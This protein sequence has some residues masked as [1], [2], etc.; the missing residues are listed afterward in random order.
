M[1]LV[2]LA[3]SVTAAPGAARAQILFS[4]YDTTAD[5]SSY[6]YMDECIAAVDRLIADERRVD[7][8]WRDTAL[9]ADE[10][11]REGYSDH[12]V[13]VAKRCM[14]KVKSDTLPLQFTFYWASALLKANRDLEVKDMYNRYVDSLPEEK[15]LSAFI[16]MLHL[17]KNARPIRMESIDETYEKAVEVLVPDSVERLLDL[18]LF[19]ADVK[20]SV[21]D[22]AGGHQYLLEAIA[23]TDTL[24]S[25]VKKRPRYLDVAMSLFLA[26]MRNL[27]EKETVDSISV[28]TQAFNSHVGSLFTRIIGGTWENRSVVNMEAPW[29]NGDFWFTNRSN[30]GLPLGRVSKRGRNEV[31]AFDVPVWGKVNLIAFLR[32]GCHSSAPPP[33]Q[34]RW[35]RLNGRPDCRPLLST[36]RR[37]NETYPEVEVTIVTRTYGFFGNSPALEPHEEADTM[38]RYFLD[39]H[40]ISGHVVVSNTP[41]FRLSSPDERRIDSDTQNDIDFALLGKSRSF[42]GSVILVD[43]NGKI[44]IDR[45]FGDFAR[46]GE[47]YTRKIIQALLRQDER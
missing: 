11:P 15:R 21:G 39:F 14:E 28:S 37:I 32:G 13:D 19:M 22:T 6:R 41:Y 34:P 44:V 30:S 36:I 23:I 2:L 40:K 43:R 16:R 20:S 12:T 31:D 10:D 47:Y 26:A 24:S 33:V 4:T 42:H 17:Y 18:K 25:E 1:A 38:A 3:L 29:V 5:Y 45:E 27:Y 8:V 7:T 9:Y 35:I 46:K